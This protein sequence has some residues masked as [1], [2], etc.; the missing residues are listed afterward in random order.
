MWTNKVH[1]YPI[2]LQYGA[3]SARNFAS[4]LHVWWERSSGTWHAALNV[5]RTTWLRGPFRWSFPPHKS[6]NKG[7]KHIAA[8]ALRACSAR[9]LS[10]SRLA[11]LYIPQ[12]STCHQLRYWR[13]RVISRSRGVVFRVDLGVNHESRLFSIVSL[14]TASRVRATGYQA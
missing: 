9:S 3:S 1:F 4:L 13:I 12:D 11:P 6:V 2:L 14:N 5:N 8:H 7:Q 10:A